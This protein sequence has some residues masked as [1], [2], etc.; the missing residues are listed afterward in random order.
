MMNEKEIAF[1]RNKAT[2]MF[3]D[4]CDAVGVIMPNTSYYYE[5]LSIIESA[6]KISA[7]IANEGIDADITKFTEE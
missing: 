1:I 4:W 3:N 2:K 6:V 5:V 7:K